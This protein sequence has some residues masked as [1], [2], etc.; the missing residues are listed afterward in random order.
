M[1]QIA[2]N[3]AEMYP[4]ADRGAGVTVVPM[5]DDMVRKVRPFLWV[6]LGAVVFLLLIACVNVAN[7][8]IV[9]AIIRAREFAIRSALGASQARV[10][11]QLLTERVL[12]GLAG[13]GIG[14]CLTSGGTQAAIRVLP[15]TLPRSEEVGLDAHVLA[16]TLAVS[17]LPAPFWS[18]ACSEDVA[19]ESPG[20]LEG[21]RAWRDWRPPPRAEC[22]CRD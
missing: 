10:I 4:N 14:W 5:K 1:N 22:V 13:G 19:P 8:Q 17:I 9:R 20:N 15:E 11:R 21:E 16:F 7:L 6:L 3:L 2:Q 12:L 18:G